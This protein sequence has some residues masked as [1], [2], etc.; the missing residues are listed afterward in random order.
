MS[1]PSYPLRW[2]LNPTVHRIGPSSDSAAHPRAPAVSWLRCLRAERASMEPARWAGLRP[3]KPPTSDAGARNGPSSHTSTGPA[4]LGC[5]TALR[6]APRF[7]VCSPAALCF[8]LDPSWCCQTG[9]NGLNYAGIPSAAS[10]GTLGG[11]SHATPATR[12]RTHRAPT[13]PTG[14]GRARTCPNL[15]NA[16][17]RGPSHCRCSEGC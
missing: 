16:A 8:R 15:P 17:Q 1:A 12:Q 10:S 3:P 7:R 5:P 2:Q 9:T 13:L 6:A 11:M 14:K 4:L